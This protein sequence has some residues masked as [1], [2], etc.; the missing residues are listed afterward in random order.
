MKKGILF[1]TALAIAAF[2]AAC[3]QT[4]TVNTNTTAN[5]NSMNRNQAMT[6][7]SNQAM[8]N[9]M[10]HSDMPM[11][12]NMSSM[13]DM[14]S[15][16]NAAAQAYDLQ[17][18][19]TMTHHHQGAIDMANMALTNSS[20]AE[21]KTFAQKIIDDQNK[22]I[23]QMKDW[24]EKWYAGK[25]MAMNMEMPGM[26]DSMKMMSGD[27]MK[28]MEAATGK[29]FDLHFLDM[30]TPHHAGAVVMAKEALQKAEH[31]EIKTLSNN[32]IKAQEAEIKEMA[33]WKAKWSK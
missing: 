9:S 7:N 28:K 3:Q 14:K 17:F 27:E 24:R 10:N 15:S 26:S 2:G 1:I 18:I 4:G 29:D 31:P 23:A 16:P 19:D 5:Q 30:M 12:S 6:M 8:S 20:N 22:E 11:N 13:S 25:P 33:D 21:L 32:I